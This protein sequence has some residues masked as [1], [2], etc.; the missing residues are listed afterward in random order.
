MHI[1]IYIYVMHIHTYTYTHIYI[2]IYIY[3]RFKNLTGLTC[4]EKELK[5]PGHGN[6]W[7]P[8]VPF[9][10]KGNKVCRVHRTHRQMAQDGMTQAAPSGG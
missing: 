5:S 8:R 3:S 4:H 10:K 9:V 1:Y 2:Y 6:Q 7:K